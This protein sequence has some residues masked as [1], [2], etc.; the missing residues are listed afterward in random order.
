MALTITLIVLIIS[1]IALWVWVTRL[2]LVINYLSMDSKENN[3]CMVNVLT[4][5][6]EQSNLLKEA[7]QRK[8]QECK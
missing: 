1:N 6:E 4:A 5:L 8:E 7:I 3:D 2:K